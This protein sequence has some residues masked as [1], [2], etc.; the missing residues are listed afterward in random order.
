M[1]N[2][3]SNYICNWFT[4]INTFVS[5][6]TMHLYINNRSVDEATNARSVTAGRQFILSTD[7]GRPTNTTTTLLW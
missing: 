2:I 5:V 4:G 7:L 1:L 6:V 3:I